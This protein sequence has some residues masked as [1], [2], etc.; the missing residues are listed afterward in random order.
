MLF[1]LFFAKNT[2]LTRS[3]FFYFLIIALYFLIPAI[4]GKSFN[5]TVELVI[6]IRIQTKE[7]KAEIETYPIT[8]EAKIRSVQY[9]LKY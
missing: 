7:E 2:I 8:T 9:N 5:L 1:N 6:L 4:I 3:F